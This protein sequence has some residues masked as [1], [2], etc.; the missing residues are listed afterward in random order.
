MKYIIGIY[1]GS[2]DPFTRGHAEIVHRASRLCDRLIVAVGKHPTKPGFFPVEERIQLIHEC[3]GEMPNVTVEV[4]S[5]LLFKYALEQQAKV[6]IRGLRAHGDF[7]AEYQLAMAN[8]D[9]APKL[10]TMFLLPDPQFQFVS[11]SLVREIAAHNGDISRYVHPAVIEAFEKRRPPV[12]S[13]F[14]RWLE[15]PLTKIP[16]FPLNRDLRVELAGRFST[17]AE[18]WALFKAIGLEPSTIRWEGS[19]ET[20]WLNILHDAQIRGK[21]RELIEKICEATRRGGA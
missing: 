7:E 21:L 18:V 14:Q 1:A 10:E 19:A 2:F 4:F 6:L 12:V 16:S 8:R 17:Q 5:G 3:L 13:P 9:A 15:L 11:S 20:S